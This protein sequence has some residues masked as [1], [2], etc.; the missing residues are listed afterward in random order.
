MSEEMNDIEAEKKGYVDARRREEEVRALKDELALARQLGSEIVAQTGEEIGNRDR[1]SELEDELEKVKEELRDRLVT[2]EPAPLTDDQKEEARKFP[3]GDIFEDEAE[4]DDLQMI[5]YPDNTPQEIQNSCVEATTQTS[6]TSSEMTLLQ[7]HIREQT[8]Y[9]VTARLDLEYMCPGETTLGLTTEQGNAKPI[10]DALLDRLRALKSQLR[11]SEGALATTRTQESNMRN[12]FNTALMQ[13]DSA[14]ST[15]KDLAAQSRHVASVSAD[16]VRQLEADIDEK[17]RS[18]GRLQKALETYR[19]EVKD[20]ECLVTRLETEHKIALT[21]L[22]SETDEA[23]ADLECHVAAETRGRREAEE[24]CEHRLQTIKQL[25]NKEV[26]LKDALNEK[27][28]IIRKLEEELDSTNQGR[29]QEVGALNVR[30]AELSSSLSEVRKDLM[31]V[32]AERSR[33]I[34]LVEVE[35]T[36]AIKVTEKMRDEMRQCLEHVETVRDGYEKDVQDRG[37]EV[38]EHQGLLTPVSAVRFK[39]FGPC[40]GYIEVRRGKTRTKRGVDSGIGILAEDE[41]EDMVMVM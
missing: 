23:V 12:Q 17:Q 6:L 31:K 24:E 11:I 15:T 39:D 10:L 28:R 18:I 36:T 13:L 26:E 16:K 2:A 27:Q 20:L 1:I 30:V 5:E 4:S 3:A 35:K 33:L 40:E 32:E 37:N 38:A 9:L 19:T 41:D 21:D 34:G 22:K 25:E 14:R 8:G 29:E 7:D